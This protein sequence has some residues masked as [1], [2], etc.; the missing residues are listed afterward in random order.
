[1]LLWGGAGIHLLCPV[2]VPAI[3]I[4]VRIVRVDINCI[5]QSRVR[6]VIFDLLDVQ[7][8][9]GFASCRSNPALFIC[10]GSFCCLQPDAVTG[11]SR[12]GLST[13]APRPHGSETIF[14]FLFPALFHRPGFLVRINAKAYSSLHSHFCDIDTIINPSAAFVNTFNEVF[15]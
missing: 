8:R 4:L 13:P 7:I 3:S 11:A 1:M 12:C 5:L 14:S 6:H 15:G 2:R 9:I 10:C